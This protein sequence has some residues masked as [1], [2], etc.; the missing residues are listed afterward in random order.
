MSVSIESIAIFF[1]AVLFT[2]FERTCTKYIEYPIERNNDELYR[3]RT[4]QVFG[5]FVSSDLNYGD[6]VNFPIQSSKIY[7][8]SKSSLNIFVIL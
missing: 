8:Q 1:T 7:F 6:S 2:L 4:V 5:S 3:I